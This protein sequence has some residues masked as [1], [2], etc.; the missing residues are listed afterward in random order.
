MQCQSSAYKVFLLDIELLFNLGLIE[1]YCIVMAVFCAL[2][3]SEIQDARKQCSLLSLYLCRVF[4][5]AE[6]TRF[7]G[8]KSV[9]HIMNQIS[10]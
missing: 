3:G 1:D 10:L 4:L 5:W 8:R 6:K 7:V 9:F 2:A